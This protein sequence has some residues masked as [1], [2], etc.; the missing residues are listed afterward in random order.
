MPSS[1]LLLVQQG[2]GSSAL[3]TRAL[4][5]RPPRSSPAAAR[6]SHR[7]AREQPL[8]GAWQPQLQRWRRRMPTPQTTPARPPRRPLPRLIPPPAPA[9]RPSPSPPG[10]SACTPT[11]PS[12]PQR[13]A[14]AGRAR[15]G[16][17]GRMGS[18]G[19]GR[20]HRARALRA[21]ARV[22]AEQ[23]RCAP[24]AGRFW[25]RRFGR[26]RLGGGA[27][28]AGLEVRPRL[29]EARRL[30]RARREEDAPRALSPGGGQPARERGAR[31]FTAT[32][33]RGGVTSAGGSGRLGGR[34][35]GAPRSG[36]G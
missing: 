32:R 24:A 18:G 20:R 17:G 10:S 4:S 11:A 14:P 2:A 35:G 29:R 16:C 25:R 3:R 8:P 27:L 12:S 21:P 15:R 34:C 19:R 28:A 23:G 36:R 5:N 7:V 33:R 1:P 13:P 22:P 26:R 6:P 30:L 9:A 31:S